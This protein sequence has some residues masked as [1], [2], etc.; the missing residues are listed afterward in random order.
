MAKKNTTIRVLTALLAMVMMLS[1]MLTVHMSATGTTYYGT[2]PSIQQISG[3]DLGTE[4]LYDQSVM[5]KLPD[6]VKAD[7]D[8]S[9]II[10]TK[11]STLLDAYDKSG[12]SL[13]FG[14]YVLTDDA[15]IVRKSIAA[16]SNRV[17]DKLEGISYKLGE[18]Y[19]TLVSGFEI[20]IKAADFEDVCKAI[21]SDASVHVGEVY[22]AAETE[23]V[24]ND[25]NVY[26]T[27]IF[28]SEDFKDKYGIDGT[29]IVVAVLDTGIDYYH[30]AFSDTTFLADRNKLGLKFED[31]QSV[32][33]NNNMAAEGMVPGLSPED[34]YISSKIPF[35]FDYADSDSD[36]F[37][38]LS[39]HGTHV[40]GVIVG[41]YLEHIEAEDY[42]GEFVGVAPNAQV[43]AMKIFSDVEST[44]HT[45]WILA[46]LED[47]VTL[48]VDVINMSIGTTCGFS[49]ETDKEFESG[50]YDKIRERGIGL[51]VAAS[52]SF[53][54][55][56]GS[57]KNGNL[58][59]TSNPDSATVGSPST[60][61]GALSVASIEGAKTPYL[62]YNNKIMYFIEST[63][64]VSKEKDFV[65]ELLPD[66][67]D[68]MTIEYVLIAGAGRTAADYTG[69][70]VKGKIALI[71]RGYNTF[72]EKAALAQEMGAAG[73]IIYNNVSGDIKMNVGETSIPVCSIS[74]N[75]GE[76]LAKAGSGTIKISRSQTS[77]PFI[78]DFSSWGPT[79]DL[80]IKPEITA[81]G[82]SILSSVP[83]EDYDRISGTSMATP[84]ISGV[85]A[86]LRQYVIE[87][88]GLDRED[89]A[90]EI[91][92]IV[93]R[94]MMSTAD[95]IINQNGLPY[96]V[97]KQGA[98]LANLNDSAA[99]NAYIVTYNE[100][101]SIMDKSKIELGDDPQKTGVY[102]MKFGIY[103]FGTSSIS[104]GLSAHVLTEGV[105]ET[106]TSHGETTVTE[107]AYK[108]DGAIIE[109]ISVRGGTQNGKNITVGA[110]QTAD[111]T[112]K[113]TLTDE[114]KKY[115]DKSFENGGYVEGFLMLTADGE[116][117]D[118]NLPYLA[119]YGD[120]TVAPL[121]DLDFFE[122]NKD[123]L[124][125]SIDPLDK[126]LADAY[127]SR[128]IGGSTGDYVSYLGSYYFEQNPT[129]K[130]IAA[131]RK[132]ISLSNQNT[133][134]EINSL[135]YVWAGML[136]GAKTIEIVITE[137]STGEVVYT[138]TESYIR[139][140]YGEGG[141]IRPANIDIEFSAIEQNLKNNT[142]YTVTLKA[143]LDYGDGG[144]DTNLNNEFTFPITTDF[145]SPTLTGCEFYT[146]YDRSSKKTRLFAKIAI[147]DNH[148]A[149][150][151]QTG[152]VGTSVDANGNSS[153]T[154]YAFDKY[155]TPI[156]SE[157]NST[158]YVT[159]ELTDYIDNIVSGSMN[160]NTFT[161]A[162]YDYAMN[163]S[164]YEI[165]LP[166]DFEAFGFTDEDG[167]LTNELHIA[168]S[169][170][171]VYN[172][173]PVVYPATEWGELLT[174][175]SSNSSS[176]RVVNNQLV[177]V[178]G[179][180]ARI[181]ARTPDGRKTAIIYVDVLQ[182]GDAGY[183]VYSK[184]VA[185]SFKLTGFYVNKAF[186]KL[187]STNRDIGS[188]GDELKFSSPSYYNL[189][190]YPSESVTLRYEL[191]AYFPQ[192]TQVVFESGN[193]SVV[194]IDASGRITAVDEGLASVT[195]KVLMD[196]KSTLYS[197]TVNIEVKEPYITSGPSLSNYFG[198]GDE[199][200]HV[201]LNDSGLAITEI[202]QFAFSNYDYVDKGANDEISEESPETMKMWFIGDNTIKKVT[203][204]EGIERI[205][206]YAF[207]NMTALETIVL[208]STLETIDYGAFLGCTSLKKIEGIENVKFI[209]QAAFQHCAITGT[210]NLDNAVAIA[211][212]AFAENP[213]IT[214]VNLPSTLQS[215]GAY[216][217]G[218]NSKLERVNI[219]AE[220]IK[221]GQYAF[222]DCV[223]LKSID[224]NA[225]VIPA[226]AFN[227]CR[228]L[229]D[230]T[231]GKDVSVISEYAFRGS[232]ISK[233]KVAEG[234]ETFVSRNGGEYLTN[235]AGDELLL[236][237]P[238]KT[239][240]TLNDE[241]ITKIGNAAFSGSDRLTK[242]SI[243]TATYIGDFAFS[244][245]ERLAKVELGKLTHIGQYAFENTA[246]TSFKFDKDLE[247]GDYAFYRS[248]IAEVVIP[249][250]YEIPQG[251]FASCDNLKRIVIGDNV[252][253]GPNAFYNDNWH[254]EVE[255]VSRPFYDSA[256][257][258]KYYKDMAVYSVAF[259]SSISYIEIGKNAIIKSGAFY[260]ASEIESIKLGAGAVIDEYAFY[261][262]SS[263]KDIDLSKVISIGDYAFSGGIYY[264]YQNEQR[265]VIDI[266]PEGQ[267]HYTYHAPKL[268]SID[269]SS[270]E[271]IGKNAFAVCK[272]L[273]TVK[274]GKNL[275]RISE[276]AFQTC[277]N[278]TTV[279]LENVEIIEGYA[280]AECNLQAADLSSATFIGEYAFCYNE[281]LP[282][283]SLKA[284]EIKIEEG[285]F[286]YCEKLE[287]IEGEENATLIGDYAFAYT[288]ITEAD[289]SSAE[290]IGTHAFYKDNVTEF[291]L[292]LGEALNNLGD[293]P[294]ANCVIAPFFTYEDV[295]FGESVMQT[296]KVYTF[297][298]SDNIK[299]IDGS[300]YRVVPKG[301]ELIAWFGDSVATVADGTV[302]IGAMAFAGDDVTKVVL[303]S[304]VAS[305]GHKAFYGCNKLQ[306][307]SFA[308]YQS[309]ILEEEYDS[310]YYESMENIPAAGVYDFMDNYN[311][312]I[313][314]EGIEIIPYF[315]WNVTSM[316]N[317]FFYGANFVDYVGKVDDKIT[318]I[319]PVNGKNYDSFIMGHY[320]A[321]R[322]EG[323]A[324]AD[325]TTLAA[326]E[327]IGKLPT[328]TGSI[329]LA[330][331]G[332][333]SAAR[334]AYNK[335][336]SDEQR[337]LVPDSLLS[338]LKACEQMIE[339]LEYLA[340]GDEESPITGNDR[341]EIKTTITVL[342][343]IVSILGVGLLGLAAFVIIIVIRIKQGKLTLQSTYL[344]EDEYVPEKNEE[345]TEENADSL[346]YDEIADEI[347]EYAE[348][349]E[350][351]EEP[352]EEINPEEP[353]EKRI[354][355]KPVDFDDITE[356]YMD[357]DAKT[358]KRKNILIICA[359]VAAV[360]LVI[361]LVVAIVTGNKSYF[362]SYNKEGYT[363]SVTF[364]S[365]GGT[366]KG[367]NSSIVDLY[368]PADIGEDGLQLLAPDDARRDK[369][370]VMQVTKPGYFLAGWYTNREL[371]DESNPE[372]GYTYSGKWD[373]EHDRVLIEEGANY[374]ADYSVLTLYA[375]WV[376]YYNFEIY[377]KDE[378][379]NS[380]LLSTVSALTLTIPEWK[381][382][383]VT[384]NMDNF[385]EREGYTL[386]TRSIYYLDSMTKVD[387][388]EVS[389]N[390]K[391]ISGKWDEATATSETPVIKLYTEWFEGKTYRI[392]STDDFVKNADT[393]GYYELYCDLD[394]TK[395]QWP[396][397][398]LN[399]KF[400]GKIY[401]NRHKVYGASFE[402]TSRSR[403]T[404]G[405]FSS[406]SENAYIEKLEFVDLTHTIDLMAVAQDATFGLLAGTA[407]DG[408]TFK[409]VTVSGKLIFG[410]NCS[411][412]AGNDS[413]TVKTLIGNGNTD[414]ITAGEILVEKQNEN[415]GDFTLQ[416]DKDGTVTILSGSN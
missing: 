169:P 38:L 287:S 397:T 56:Y 84:N 55:S 389:G 136:R 117:Q 321:L 240:F 60:Y 166:D 217:F 294:F 416:V 155:A 194:K 19:N 200:N 386:D 392:Y 95:I 338:V 100:D 289:L 20:I 59:L 72:E 284:D 195:A 190:L 335:I 245:C 50:V 288:L 312:P 49:R 30:S 3:I 138:A 366:F 196:G 131:D 193:E 68:E 137:D 24:E 103:N 104:Y 374:S 145:S 379:G 278:L 250:G 149:M 29:G 323:A 45:S 184:P 408:A 370:N 43:V 352:I 88:F 180:G 207:A 303:P 170:N 229:T 306:F 255:T 127:A 64:R 302:R 77:G 175:T 82:G 336:I 298:L 382:G 143:Y 376:P 224:I 52:N 320:F 2:S 340:D 328:D 150:A 21:G 112:V 86:L 406:L 238:S 223:S 333:V 152:Y 18:S 242:V 39:N 331:K 407:A 394:F 354:F 283:V 47:C 304:T 70:D 380:Y 286:S 203:L 27:G 153:A 225:S 178:G 265:T 357:D 402:S 215:L 362:H 214:E 16:E 210:L 377:T 276:G 270:L 361:A 369:N 313:K 322:V 373:F 228:S 81:H 202:G 156:Y 26:G 176:V 213:A 259:D 148:Y 205:G 365:N 341:N 46:A 87:K 199:Y 345:E 11:S 44:S 211:N 249:D 121:F 309:P 415:N 186:Y 65:E 105:S 171:E 371:I 404:N 109:I 158:T 168:L 337:A 120:W 125:D 235:K 37:P 132:Y 139:K 239:E 198:A 42:T 140:S 219:K 295:I 85:A 98:G 141:E 391:I 266:T 201:N 293:N 248:D 76:L 346:G 4:K 330:D 93:N 231:L 364:D 174:Y 204:S 89:D 78:S 403:L 360:A 12:S 144:V 119:F 401:G 51:I 31:I 260:G 368:N 5:Y 126:N 378:S 151:M 343:V 252:T 299:I 91:T 311:N 1:T 290:Y 350:P 107:S 384:L 332:L 405:L 83:G 191:H 124:D 209:N 113:I 23:L 129:N 236:V 189:S 244:E 114:N 358:V 326:I 22:E 263:L 274:L 347:T 35:G 192:T 212:Y 281:E 14:D 123:E 48:G 344:Y 413:F 372:L 277:D 161:I 359:A 396:S 96:S 134:G 130:I 353:F 7:F 122:T 163:S 325:D 256:T 40:S 339:D 165:A 310:F 53:N 41:N 315:M 412:L 414:G 206:P 216:A 385:P 251:A 159:Y 34:V 188:T 62:L 305:I 314:Y 25:V 157:F 147:Y 296:N 257:G 102:T 172:L 395:T 197:A 146:E 317:N 324:A 94:L 349:E 410:D 58:P 173:S 241:K 54:S 71:K 271:S 308:S 411:A 160:K 381:D 177:A 388:A 97:R 327:A 292:T 367:S 164:T 133:N 226:G 221:L 99:T 355:D 66:G 187:D 9:V 300:L 179:T 33:I 237:A 135:R 182:E 167:A 32:M 268:V 342:I 61:L 10:E 115:L 15:A 246:I 351:Q 118:L 230:V 73:V 106:K 393:E 110:G 334:A 267:Y 375:A 282:S 36:V 243:P 264:K 291:T 234:N 74:Q 69:I 318:M 279:N 183:K 307:I 253:I 247:I 316:P 285:A 63:D 269:L 162:C 17:K 80:K 181:T 409:N 275:T 222:T 261:N 154:F 262:C 383:D 280:F 273:K 272:E 6:T 400:N 220:K 348:P 258:G 390:K 398:F 92:A 185:E 363:V 297:D 399:G 116:E 142:Q 57:E 79:P 319:S 208:P 356:G 8:I 108:L 75:D 101:G 254:M 90:K 387:D 329:T 233:F 128:P 13:S 28:S 111:V 67:K 301:L 218:A 232:A 227:Q